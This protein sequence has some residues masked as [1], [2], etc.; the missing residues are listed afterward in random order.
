MP[1]LPALLSAREKKRAIR[2]GVGLNTIEREPVR[3]GHLRLPDSA[4]AP[5]IDRLPDDV[6]Q[7]VHEACIQLE[8]FNRG[9]DEVVDGHAS[10]A[11]SVDGRR[12][13]VAAGTA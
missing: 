4:V 13:G 9:T 10:W 12:I 3:D 11:G 1:H 8:P 2:V 6:F 7:N 5:D